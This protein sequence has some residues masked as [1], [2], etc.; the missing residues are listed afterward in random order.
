MENILTKNLSYKG[1]TSIIK[2]SNED[3]TF[4]GK[5]E[6]IK[7]LIIFEIDIR[8][9]IELHFENIVNAYIQD[10]KELNEQSR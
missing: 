9:D 2:Y 8:E 3:N 1:Y 10:R 6:N 5:L 4:Y 7:D